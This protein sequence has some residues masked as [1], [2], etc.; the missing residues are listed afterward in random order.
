MEVT[1]MSNYGSPD[2]EVVAEDLAEFG[3]VVLVDDASPMQGLSALRRGIE[4]DAR[5]QRLDQS[6]DASGSFVFVV[7]W[8]S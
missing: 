5:S 4:A 1:G 3:L 2:R 7:P 8:H 6:D